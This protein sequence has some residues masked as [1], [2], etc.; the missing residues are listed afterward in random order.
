MGREGGYWKGGGETRKVLLPLM[1]LCK[2]LIGSWQ[3]ERGRLFMRKEGTLWE[4]RKEETP[5]EGEKIFDERLL[6]EVPPVLY[7]GALLWQF[8]QSVVQWVIEWFCYQVLKPTTLKVPTSVLTQ[9]PVFTIQPSL[10]SSSM[11]PKSS[12]QPVFTSVR[13]TLLFPLLGSMGN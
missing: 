1:N 8:D 12:S 3:E 5:W 10:H 11:C 6:G 4:R 13:Y 7:L 9:Y 2:L